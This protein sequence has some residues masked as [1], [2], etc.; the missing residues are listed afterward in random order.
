M[1]FLKTRILPLFL[2]VIVSVSVLVVPASANA[3]FPDHM[4]DYESVDDWNARLLGTASTTLNALAEKFGWSAT[5]EGVFWGL[6]NMRMSNDLGQVEYSRLCQLAEL[7]NQNFN[8][9]VQESFFLQSIAGGVEIANDTLAFLTLGTLSPSFTVTYSA[10]NECYRIIEEKTGIF[11]VDSAGRYPYALDIAED[12]QMIGNKWIGETTAADRASREVATYTLD[13]LNMLVQNLKKEGISAQI[14]SL[15]NNYKCVWWNR[16]VLADSTGVPILCW[17][18]DKTATK[19]ERPDAEV[20]VNGENVDVIEGNQTNLNLDNMILQLPDGSLQFIDKVI[21]DESTKSYHIDSHDTYNYEVN[22][23]YTWN[24]YINYTSITYIGQTEEYN[25]YYEVYY[26]LPDGRSSADLTKEDLEQLN[27]SVDV[28]PYGRSAD[29]TSLRSLYHFDGDTKDS[30]YWNYCTD[31][32]WNKGASLT[33]MDAG[34]FD[35]ALYLDETEHDFTFTLP[36][37]LGSGDFTFQFRYYQS[38]TEA[39]V[40][41]SY[42]KFGDIEVMKFNGS[43]LLHYNGNAISAMPVGSWNEIAL[44]RE[45]GIVYYYLNG[46]QVSK[47]SHLGLNSFPKQITFHFGNEQQTFK[48]FDELR[49][50]NKAIQTGGANYECSS[51][52]HDTNL[53]LIL[54]TESAPVADEYWNFD[55]SITPLWSLDFTD[56]TGEGVYKDLNKM[57]GLNY[58]TSRGTSFYQDGSYASL[59]Q[60][61]QPSG[62]SDSMNQSQMKTAIGMSTSGWWTPTLGFSVPLAFYDND[63]NT[64][65]Y[66]TNGDTQVKRDPAYKFVNDQVFTFTVVERSGEQTSY[67][68]TGNPYLTAYMNVKGTY[69]ADWGTIRQ[70]AYMNNGYMHC[71]L[72]LNVDAGKTLDVVYMELVEGS[73]PNTGHEF[74]SSVT[75]IDK[76]DLNTPTLAVR[77]D[78]EITSYQIGGVRPSIPEKGQVW[79]MVENDRIVS[80]QIYNGQAWEGV[81][82]RIWTGQR[83]I[84]ASSYNIITLQ[85]MYDIVDATPNYEYIYSEAGFWAWWQKS[86]NAFTE[87]LFLTLGSGGTGGGASGGAGSSELNKVDL[88]SAPVVSDPDEEDGKSLWQFIVLVVNGGKSVV[89]GTREM[90]SGVVSTIPD[91]MDDITGAFDSGGVAVGV[92]DGSDPDAEDIESEVLDPWRYQ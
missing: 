67:T 74:V 64:G 18:D 8:V 21:Y 63:H 10:S 73:T 84:P 38:H 86:W 40:T 42:I 51:V 77:T 24:Y 48:Y 17:V 81:D 33:Y 9:P 72:W 52:P 70:I 56:G 19:V 15:S 7:F 46:V 79:A 14:K 58:W 23:Y 50:L 20:T 90:F 78:G 47:D 75:G 16:Q 39:P 1:K 76:A 88:D 55:K 92:F 3:S 53:S 66:I 25:K 32:T 59:S 65:M 26:E 82:G 12:G 49:V 41:D 71:V 68:F 27:L 91:T 4:R 80:I 6:V 69:T 29:D 89:S 34:V 22:N 35:G 83:W 85:D 62:L 61:T 44:V 28:I 45:N 57:G 31:F 43:S 2:A 30:S 11:V 54:P 37:G 36:S 60:T 13:Q 5:V 87:K